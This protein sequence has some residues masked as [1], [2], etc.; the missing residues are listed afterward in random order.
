MAYSGSMQCRP[1]KFLAGILLAHRSNIGMGK[2]VLCS[3]FVAENDIA[4]KADNRF[5][6]WRGKVGVAEIM[7]RVVDFDADR[8][9]VDV[10]TR[11]PA[12][13]SGMPGPQGLVD[14]LS[15]RA[16]LV[17]EVMTGNTGGRV[18]QPVA[19]GFGRFHAGVMQDQEL[20]PINAAARTNIRRWVPVMLELRT[21][22]DP[23]ALAIAR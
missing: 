20:G 2:D 1:G 18:A 22:H 15:D 17:Y 3:D 9:R 4:A 7:A 10:L 5:H 11:F 8:G 16:F 19:C 21:A 6:L 12:A 14:H 23:R 13:Y